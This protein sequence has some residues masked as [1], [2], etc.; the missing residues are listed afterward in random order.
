MIFSNDI[1]EYIGTE[2]VEIV[3]VILKFNQKIKTMEKY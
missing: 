1:V 3:K 2:R